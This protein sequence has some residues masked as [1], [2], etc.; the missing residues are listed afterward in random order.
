MRDV[1]D[2]RE[3]AAGDVCDGDWKPRDAIEMVEGEALCYDRNFQHSYAHHSGYDPWLLS[4][5]PR[6]FPWPDVQ[7]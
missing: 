2:K 5:A 6:E 4:L 7:G 3:R 1:G